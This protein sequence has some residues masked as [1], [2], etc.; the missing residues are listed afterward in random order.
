MKRIL[1]CLIALFAITSNASAFDFSAV[2]PSGQTLYYNIV[3][4]NAQVTMLYDVEGGP[5]YNNLSGSLTIPTSVS[6]NS[7]TYSVTSIGDNAFSG[8][9]GLTSITIPNSVTSIGN[10]AFRDCSGLTSITIPNSVTSIGDNAFSGCSGLTSITIPNS[11]TSIGYS[12]FLGC[13]NLNSIVVE[14]GNSVYDSRNNCNAIIETSTN[15]VIQGCMNTLIPNSVTAIGDYAFSGCSGL[16]SITIPNSVTSIGDGAFRNCSGLTSITIPNSVTSIGNNAF[17]D[18]SGLTSITIPNSVTSIG[19]DAFSDCSGLTSI[20]IGNSVTNISDYAFSGCSGL[21][22]IHSLNNVPPM[23]YS[24]TFNGIPTNIPVYIPCGRLSYYTS[25]TGWSRF[26]NFVEGSAY[27]FSA[28]SN[29]EIMGSVQIL[30]MPSC[31][32]PQ[33]VVYAVA[34]SGY[35]FDHWSDNS[36]SNP[37]SLTVNED[38]ELTAYFVPGGGGEQP[39]TDAPAIAYVGVDGNGHN[40]VHWSAPAANNIVQYNVYREG[41]GGYSVAGYVMWHGSGEYTWVDDNSNPATQAYSYKIAAQFS[42]GS[43]S[44]KSAAHTTIHLQISQGQGATWNLSWTPYG[45]FS[46]DGYRIFRRS[47]SNTMSLLTSVVSSATSF[48]DEGTNGDVYYQIE[49]VAGNSAKTAIS[50]RSNIATSNPVQTYTINVMSANT[51]M[52]SVSGGGEYAVGMPAV[53]SA[54]AST[55]YRFDHWSDGSTDESRLITVMGSASYV[56]YF[57]VDGSNGIDDITYDNI[58]IYSRGNEIVIEGAEYSDALV[59]D[60]MGRIVHKGRIEGPICVNNKGV[61]MVKIGTNPPRK[62]VVR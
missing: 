37:Y 7:T 34:N 14:S 1:F 26:T 31:T 2:A 33:A 49:V 23:A 54:H 39:S 17:R 36:T 6:H 30:T 62:V 29:N 16:T 19:Y 61:Y 4:G 13:T 52:G 10:N 32:N 57:S 56:A 8:C 53:I 21:T 55:G 18:C 12:P 48:S 25:A 42:N 28:V 5:N 44:G 11:V 50:S 27:V 9:S 24:N 35:R 41:L 46:Y 47:T 45:G 58:K 15:T 60:V 59:Y 22:E 20:T 40:A 38:M 51:A 3:N 43:E